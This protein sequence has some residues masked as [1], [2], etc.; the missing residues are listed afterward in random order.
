MAPSQLE[1]EDHTRDAEFNR[2]LHG[3][4]S[5]ARGGLFA[6]SSKDDDAQKAAVDEYFKHWDNKSAADE[7][8]E[9]RAVSPQFVNWEKRSVV[10]L[11]GFRDYRLGERNM[12]HSPDSM[13]STPAPRFLARW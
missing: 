13:D 5:Q 2:A 9:T 4:S 3:K 12:L 1:K 8:E 10:V 6:M 7:T 11:I